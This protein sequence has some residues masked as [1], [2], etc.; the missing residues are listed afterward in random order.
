MK[1]ILGAAVAASAMVGLGW[2][3][4]AS[5]AGPGENIARGARYT[6][7]P[8]PNYGHCSDAGDATQLGRYGVLVDVAVGVLVDVAVGVA[9][10][11]AVDVG[12]GVGTSSSSDSPAEITA[13][14]PST[15]STVTVY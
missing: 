5:W 13:P 4:G 12:V 8:A 1:R 10:S 6:L 11:V 14:L 9:V 2:T 3:P 7:A 15:N